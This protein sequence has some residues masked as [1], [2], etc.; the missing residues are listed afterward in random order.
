MRVKCGNFYPV[1][2]NLDHKLPIYSSRVLTFHQ[3]CGKIPLTMAKLALKDS[4][5]RLQPGDIVFTAG[6][7][8]LSRLIRW[9]SRRLGE[10]KTQV[11]HVGIITGYGSLL[12]AQVTEALWHVVTRRLWDGYGNK[13]TRVAIARPTNIEL[14]TRVSIAREALR[15]TDRHYGWWK[16]MLHFGDKLLGGV[17]FFRRLAQIKKYPICSFLVAECY[18]DYGYDFGVEVGEAQPDDIWDYCVASENYKFLRP[19]ERMRG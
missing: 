10:S 14:S 4:A 2:P 5:L 11:N 18:G 16:L 15:Y 17:Y 3:L 12:T 1:S 19:L 7:S 13:R 8:L 9:G 6:D